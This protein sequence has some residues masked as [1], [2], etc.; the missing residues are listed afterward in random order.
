MRD[1]TSNVWPAWTRSKSALL[2]LA[3]ALGLGRH[4][5]SAGADGGSGDSASIPVAGSAA[6]V[7][8]PEERDDPGERGLLEAHAAPGPTP[9]R[10]RGP[11]RWT[12]S[13]SPGPAPARAVVV[14]GQQ[15]GFLCDLALA[16]ALQGAA[17]DRA[18][19]ATLA[20]RAGSG[21][22]CRCSGTTP[23]T[24]TSPRSTTRTSST[25]NLDLQKRRARGALQSGRTPIAQA[26]ARRRA[27]AP[28]S[29]RRASCSTRCWLR[30]SSPH[31]EDAVELFFPREGETLARGADPRV[32]RA[33]RRARA[34]RP[35]AGLDPRGPLA[36]LAGSGRPAATRRARSPSGSRGLRGLGLEA[37]DRPDAVRRSSSGV[38]DEGRREALRVGRRRLPVRRRARLAHGRGARG[39]RS[40]TS[41]RPGRRRR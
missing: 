35:R 40:S 22:S 36:R 41:P 37:D 11:R 32:D 34:R 3:T 19:R 17:R 38:D 29:P 12:A 7:P 1:R 23:T 9:A 24:T 16:D 25:E 27:P 6:E 20:Q 15:P 14:T 5:D 26:S 28:A 18:W 13:R 8:V 2:S 31:A 4:R 33:A 39:L 30:R 10:S 21:P